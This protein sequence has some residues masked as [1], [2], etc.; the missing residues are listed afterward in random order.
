MQDDLDSVRVL[1]KP[2]TLK[3]LGLS[4]RTWDRLIARGETPPKIQ[5]STNRIGYRVSDLKQ[6]LDRRRMSEAA[7]LVAIA[8]VTIAAFST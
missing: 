8:F 4:S 2:Q 7:A 6:W 3:M 1:T 5:I